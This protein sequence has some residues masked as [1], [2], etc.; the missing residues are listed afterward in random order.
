MAR[1]TWRPNPCENQSCDLMR[2]IGLSCREARRKFRPRRKLCLLCEHTFPFTHR[3]WP[4][5]HRRFALCTR[6]T[7]PR[8]MSCDRLYHKRSQSLTAA[9][10]V[11]TR[12]G[13]DPER[14]TAEKNSYKLQLVLDA[15]RL[16]AE[17]KRLIVRAVFEE[18]GA[19]E[20]GRPRLKVMRARKK[21]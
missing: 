17:Q 12:N 21:K 1:K 8:C 11:M 5:R 20:K 4:V 15:R 7:Q 14:L 13:I 6:N 10:T 9:Q 19:G 16:S 2:H 3:H 18:W